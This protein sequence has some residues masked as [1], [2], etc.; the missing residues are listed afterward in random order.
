MNSPRES[1]NVNSPVGE[2]LE[3]DF[4]NFIKVMDDVVDKVK[5]HKTHIINFAD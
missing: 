3:I 5:K 1:L 2:I 4:N